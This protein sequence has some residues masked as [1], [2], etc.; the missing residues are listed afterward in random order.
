MLGINTTN[1]RFETGEVLQ[2]IDCY[3]MEVSVTEV[4]GVFTLSSWKVL[5]TAS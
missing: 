1:T 3:S 5:C 4:R 2:D